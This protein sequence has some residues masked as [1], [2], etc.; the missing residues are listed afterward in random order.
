MSPLDG[1][2]M[3]GGPAPC[4]DVA[5]LGCAALEQACDGRCTSFD[6][7][8]HCGACGHDC[9]GGTCTQGQCGPVVLASGLSRVAG[10]NALPDAV[11]FLGA[12]GGDP[13]VMHA[14][15]ESIDC[16]GTDDRCLLP[17]PR[18]AFAPDAGAG[19]AQLADLSVAGDYLFT[20]LS[21]LGAARRRLSALPTEPFE[22]LPGR[23]D[24]DVV[25]TAAT[26][27]ALFA[28]ANDLNWI[29]A[30]TPDGV[31]ARAQV[32][33]APP[34]PL[35]VV[36][37][38]QRHVVAWVSVPAVSEVQPGLHLIP[39]SPTETPCTGNN[40]IFLQV[41]VF[42]LAVRDEELL[43]ALAEDREHL[44]LGW[45]PADA[46]T[47]LPPECPRTLV[48]HVEAASRTDQ[49]VR[50]QLLLDAKDLFW[51]GGLSGRMR[52]FRTPRNT[53]C[54]GEAGTCEV[55]L[56]GRT[57]SGLAQDDQTIFAAV[58]REG[59]AYSVVRIAK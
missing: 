22:A 20:Y 4:N 46:A 30:I 36:A 39:S 33:T 7:P 13:R 41:P 17:A 44:S 26:K 31:R 57:I 28:A 38:G 52:L 18:D 43:V 12:G 1:G 40:C 35:D 8:H 32:D 42:G 2:G 56:E 15:R 16:F 25:A 21:R 11:V 58:D 49:Q 48:R 5:C 54:D 50:T 3:D 9:Q 6:D 23:R 34:A 29:V 10:L 37:R 53:P 59:E 19:V 27:S 14:P 47:C 24:M 55:V 45:I 51:V